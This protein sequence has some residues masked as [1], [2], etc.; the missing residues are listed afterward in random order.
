HNSLISTTIIDIMINQPPLA[1]SPNSPPSVYGL[2]KESLA[3]WLAEFRFSPFHLKPLFKHIY[4][5]YPMAVSHHTTQ[6][7][8][9]K[10]SQALQSYFAWQKCL[11]HSTQ[12]SA[13]DHSVKL[14]IQLPDNHSVETVILPEATRLTICVSS[15]VGCAQACVFCATGRMKLI[16]QL[17]TFEIIEQILLAQI[18][19]ND[20]PEWL[21]QQ[22]KFRAQRRNSQ[23]RPSDAMTNLVFMG[24]GEPCD[25][26]EAV[27]DALS[28][29]LNPCG[30]GFAPRKVTL[31]TA[32]H[33]DGLKKLY[34]QFPKL[35]YAV[36]IHAANS[37]KRQ[38]LLPINHRYPLGHLIEF[39]AETSTKHQKVFLIQYTLIEGINDS[40]EDAEALTHL[41]RGVLCKINLL[42]LN[43]VPFLKWRSPSQHKI[44]EFA[45]YLKSQNFSV[46]IRHSKAQDVA[47][48]CG[49]LASHSLTNND[50]ILCE[51]M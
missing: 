8:G 36:S 19:I 40:E 4:S 44:Y 17:S 11:I 18:W 37:K 27:R 25:N 49:Q 32:G 33:I 24:M 42:S 13:Q 30:L 21:H 26:V 20:H 16:R 12:I 41:L 45:S 38:K 3:R 50:K 28:I 35:S 5:H 46:T 43:P 39:M 48:A 51:S 47:G 10:L 29:I 9:A 1:E 14:L 22:T 15:Q 34:H 2:T 23:K 31:S 6:V 7:F